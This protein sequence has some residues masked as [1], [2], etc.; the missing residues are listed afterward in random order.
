MVDEKNNLDIKKLQNQIEFEDVNFVYEKS[1]IV[2]EI[3]RKCQNQD[4]ML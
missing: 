1:F 4:I 3:L 2:L